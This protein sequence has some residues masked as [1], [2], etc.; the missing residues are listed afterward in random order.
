MGDLWMTVKV[1]PNA[2]KDALISLSPGR[3]EA[4]VRTKPMEGRANEA[5]VN[6]LVRHLQVARDEVRLV[7]GHRGRVK[8]FKINEGVRK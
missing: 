4:W 2:G 6:L 8:V 7:K 5:V 1:H 3:F